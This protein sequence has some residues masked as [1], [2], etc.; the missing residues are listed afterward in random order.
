MTVSMVVWEEGRGRN[1]VAVH[2]FD[3]LVS[4]DFDDL[5]TGNLQP[6]F[7]NRLR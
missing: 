2:S 6:V 1:P 3:D 4:R 5:M 7:A